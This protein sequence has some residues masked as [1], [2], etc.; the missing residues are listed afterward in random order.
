MLLLNDFISN[1]KIAHKLSI[2]NRPSSHFMEK[3]NLKLNFAWNILSFWWLHAEPK[4]W[5]WISL[6]ICKM[7]Y[8]MQTIENRPLVFYTQG[9]NCQILIIVILTP[10]FPHVQ[11]N[12]NRCFAEG[13][14]NHNNKEMPYHIHCCHRKQYK[15]DKRAF[16]YLK[17]NTFVLIQVY[18]FQ[19]QAFVVCSSILTLFF[20]TWSSANRFQ[21]KH[22][23]DCQPC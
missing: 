10:L 13:S 15:T 19:A 12:L 22:S 3:L 21:V 23:T 4:L 8:P 17:K 18:A 16:L 9:N 14:E 6:Q 11:F 7:Q 5:D 2:K 20:K 1:R